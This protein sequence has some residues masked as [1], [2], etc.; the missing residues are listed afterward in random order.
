MVTLFNYFERKEDSLPNSEGP[1]FLEVLFYQLIR[2]KM[3]TIFWTMDQKMDHWKMV[4]FGPFGPI[5]FN[6][7]QMV[8]FSF[9]PME[10]GPNGSFFPYT[11]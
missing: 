4:Q 5:W 10:N 8:H 11:M 9:G 3:Y 6:L 2:E 1:V 7:V